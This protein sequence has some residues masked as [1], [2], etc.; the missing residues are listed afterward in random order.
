MAVTKAEAP[1]L[2]A[3]ARLMV[4]DHV[5]IESRSATLANGGDFK[6]PDGRGEDGDKTMATLKPLSDYKFDGDFFKIADRGSQQ[7][8]QEVLGRRNWHAKPGYQALRG[9]DSADPQT[10]FGIGDGRT[11]QFVG[12]RTRQQRHAGFKIRL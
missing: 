6:L 5:E 9:G 10:A 11:G 4:N 12:Q 3:F 7:R 1:A 2:K 8:S